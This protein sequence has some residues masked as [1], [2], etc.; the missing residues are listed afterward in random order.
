[1][2]RRPYATAGLAA[3]IADYTELLTLVN[4]GDQ[5]LT[6]ASLRFNKAWRDTGVLTNIIAASADGYIDSQRRRLF[7]RG[8]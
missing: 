5:H 4:I 7:G 2:S 1:M 8:V 3:I 6:V